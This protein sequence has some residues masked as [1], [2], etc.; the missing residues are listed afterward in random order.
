M[1]KE[2]RKLD[3]DNAFANWDYCIACMACYNPLAIYIV[4]AGVVFIAGE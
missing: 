4:V 3:V 2:K 1:K